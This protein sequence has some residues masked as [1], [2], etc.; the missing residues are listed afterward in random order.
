VRGYGVGVFE[1][2]ISLEVGLDA[3]RAEHMAADFDL[4]P[5]I[6][7]L[8]AN[9]AVGVDPVHLS[10]SFVSSLFSRSPAWSSIGAHAR[11]RVGPRNIPA[12]PVPI[13][14]APHPAIGDG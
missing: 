7:R 14:R 12:C 8:P 10:P 6:G 13:S 3:G 1:R 9:H 2:A 11:H 4:E 5:G